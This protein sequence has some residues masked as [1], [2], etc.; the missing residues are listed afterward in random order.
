MRFKEFIHNELAGVFGQVGE[1]N[2]EIIGH[3]IEKRLNVSDMTKSRNTGKSTIKR[4]MSAG[5]GVASTPRPTGIRAP[6]NPLTI[7]S[8]IT[9][10][11][12]KPKLVKPPR[13]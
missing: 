12:K 1:I 10:P 5:P 7:P 13:M 3:R 9:D 6:N 2:P 4:M 11:P 8:K